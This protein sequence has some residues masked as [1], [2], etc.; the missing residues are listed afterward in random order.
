[1][2]PLLDSR[3]VRLAGS[4]GP[5]DVRRL[6]R[7]ADDSTQNEVVFPPGWTRPQTG[8]FAGA[9][10]ALWLEGEFTMNGQTFGPGTY[11]WFP[12]GYVREMSFTK[13]GARALAWFAGRPVW[14]AQRD[15]TALTDATT[16]DTGASP[17]AHPAAD[18]V[19]RHITDSPRTPGPT[20]TSSG[21]RL[22]TT[23]D[24]TETWLLDH[25]EGVAVT[26][27][28]LVVDLDGQWAQSFVAGQTLPTVASPVLLRLS[29]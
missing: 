23:P 14:T 24:G 15:P 8:S 1:M 6:L 5:V 12:P 26:A 22:R 27:T 2:F 19:I 20:G 28:T 7:C 18:V 9:E 29:P 3:S 10:E 25:L 11:C 16:P 17:P 4:S 13:P 21:R